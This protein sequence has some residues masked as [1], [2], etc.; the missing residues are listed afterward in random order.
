M[1]NLPSKLIPDTPISDFNPHL[2][3]AQT[4]SRSIYAN[5]KKRR[6]TM[7]LRFLF[8]E[9]AARSQ[10]SSCFPRNIAAV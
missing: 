4:A 6:R 2:N 7:R 1:Q 5:V 8:R 10:L 3:D 9:N